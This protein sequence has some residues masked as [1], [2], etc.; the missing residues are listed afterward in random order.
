M[1]GSPRASTNCLRATSSLANYS[2]MFTW[3]PAAHSDDDNTRWCWLR[4]VEWINW[5]LFLSQSLVP[6]FLLF[7]PWPQVIGGTIVCN[8]VWYFLVGRRGAF[9]SVPLAGV[10]PF[11]TRLKWLVCPG[12]AVYFYFQ[13]QAD[14]CWIALLWPLVVGTPVIAVI[15]VVN[16]LAVILMPPAPIRPIQ[17]RFMMALGYVLK[18]G[19]REE[20][21]AAKN[22]E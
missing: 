10:G 12:F 13:G 7:W 18:F 21:L 20:A 17:D 3:N 6:V 8:W 9:I 14:D 19:S 5:P 15:P 11:I 16:I 2:G 22:T 4:A 1:S